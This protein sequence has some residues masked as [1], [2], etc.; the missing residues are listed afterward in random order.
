[1]SILSLCHLISLHSFQFHVI[2]D[3]IAYP[4]SSK[5]TKMGLPQKLNKL[6]NMHTNQS[7]ITIDPMPAET[8][9]MNFESSHEPT[10]HSK[11]ELFVAFLKRYSGIQSILCP[12]KNPLFATIY[13]LYFFR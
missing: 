6:V 5:I 12:K 4:K 3:L 11:L 1:M 10:L 7:K 2:N 9:P 8:P 13:C